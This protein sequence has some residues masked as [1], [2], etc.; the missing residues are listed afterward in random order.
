MRDLVSDDD[1][2]AAVIKRLGEVLAVEQR[3]QDPS[4]ENYKSRIDLVKPS[5]ERR[6]SWPDHLHPWLR[7]WPWPS[8]SLTDIILIWVVEGVDDRRLSRPFVLV[9]RLSQLL[10]VLL[11]LEAQDVEEVLQEATLV[12]LELRKARNA[13]EPAKNFLFAHG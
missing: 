10:H 13:F 5:R 1:P 12:N 4:W 2:D 6:R 9:H 7:R 11:R 8:V 3:L